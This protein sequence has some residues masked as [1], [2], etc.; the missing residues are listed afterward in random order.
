MRWKQLNY[1]SLCTVFDASIQVLYIFE[2]APS[3]SKMLKK[4]EKHTNVEDNLI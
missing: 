4:I 1:L 2:N 3:T